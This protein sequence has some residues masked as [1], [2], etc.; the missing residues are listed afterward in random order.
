MQLKY[1]K[2][3]LLDMSKPVFIPC[4]NRDFVFL[5]RIMSGQGFTRVM[6]VLMILLGVAEAA[7][8]QNTL[9]RKRSL[10]MG[11]YSMDAVKEVIL[12]K[13]A[14]TPYPKSRESGWEGIPSDVRSA[15]IREAEEVLGTEWPALPATVFMEYVRTGNRS[16]FQ[17]LSFERRRRLAVLVLAESMEAE[18]RFLD[19]IVNGIWT[20]C[21]ESFWGVP[22]HLY[23]QEAGAGLPDV[24]EPTV[25]L[26]AAETGSLLAWT[27]YLVGD[28]LDKISPLISERIYEEVN[29]RILTPNLERDDFWWMGFEGG[30][31]NNWNPWVNSNWLTV[32]LLLERDEERR[33][34]AI[35]KIMQSLDLFIDSYP[36]D[37]GCDEGPGYWSRA[38]GSLY[39]SLELLYSASEGAISIYDQPLIMKMGQYIYRS[40][41]AGSYFLNFAD[42]S[43]K[44]K[45]DPSLVFRYGQAVNDTLMTGFAAYLAELN[46][47]GNGYIPGQFGHLNRQLPALFSLNA[48]KATPA[49]EPLLTDFWFENLEI[50]GGR[51]VAN[52]REG[53]Y[54]A[55]KGGNNNES[56]NHNDIGNV[57]VYHNG[58]P[59]VI[60]VGAGEYTAKTFSKDRYTIWNMQSA[61]HNVPTINGVMQ[62]AGA[63]YRARRVLLKSSEPRSRFQISLMSAYPEEADVTNWIRSVQLDRGERVEVRDEYQLGSISGPTTLNYM[64]PRPV[65][66]V[67]P[68][69]LQLEGGS[70]AEALPFVAVYMQYD[71]ELLD[72]DVEEI[73]LEDARLKGGWGD[74]LYRIVF[75]VKGDEL[76]GDVAVK[77]V[78]SPE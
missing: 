64:T 53:F 60:D 7:Q 65:R 26:F 21:E 18:G 69:L 52:S 20:I 47:Y 43:A 35:Y 36:D 13:D 40:Y 57:I 67:E 58:Y 33:T 70:T 23:L 77:F 34:E 56:H 39:D 24:T 37:G 71:P 9:G 19:E 61:Y 11:S 3:H 16:N 41:I 12:T 55:A 25:D 59:V 29:R 27:H 14:W 28:Q 44:T 49:V 63:E 5:S 38:A 46:A 42:A 51:S 22:A 54:Y 32:A 6:V 15:H 75:T 50:Q 72:V 48:L 78:E 8:A 68:G 66:V 10:L 31:I 74:R 1:W 73:P 30:R 17:A 45:P 62:K 4:F 2:K 76:T